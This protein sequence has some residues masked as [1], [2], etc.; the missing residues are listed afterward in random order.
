MSIVLLTYQTSDGK[1]IDVKVDVVIRRRTS[2]RAQ[3]TRSPIEDGSTISDHA[4]VEPVDLSLD[5]LR[6]DTPIVV[7]DDEKQAGTDLTPSQEAYAALRYALKERLFVTCYTAFDYFPRML[8]MALSVPESKEETG[9][10]FATVDLAEIVLATSEE[11]TAPPPPEPEDPWASVRAALRRMASQN[12]IEANV[13]APGLSE[14][15]DVQDALDEVG[16]SEETENKTF[17]TSVL[18]RPL[19]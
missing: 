4:T 9:G 11:V 7:D 17:D 6:S 13:E 15:G 19:G 14:Q 2:M 16:A 5:I 3:V 12:A 1:D 8:I 10:L 18:D